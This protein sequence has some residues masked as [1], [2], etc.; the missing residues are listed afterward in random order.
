MTPTLLRSDA[1][2]VQVIDCSSTTAVNQFDY[3]RLCS[4]ATVEDQDTKKEAYT[5]LQAPRERTVKG[6]SCLV[7][8]TTFTTMCGVWAHLKFLKI[9]EI[10]IIDDIAPL[11]CQQLVADGGFRIPGG[12]KFPAAMNEETI[13]RADTLGVL[14]ERDGKL[15]CKGQQ[16]RIGDE[17]VEDVLAISQYRVVLKEE[18]FTIRNNVVEVNSAHLQLNCEAKM[19]GCVTAR[20]TYLWTEPAGCSLQEVSRP[21]LSSEIHI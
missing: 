15:T 18:V 10:E 17:I 12:N 1:Y 7:I 9:P 2:R 19:R 14:Q 13:I 20:G 3:N 21:P 11:A 5:I 6:Y 16:A 4:P 8:R